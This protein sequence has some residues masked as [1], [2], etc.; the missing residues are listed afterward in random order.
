MKDD[1]FK[2]VEKEL[3]KWDDSDEAREQDKKFEE[4]INDAE[5]HHADTGRT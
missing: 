4:E 2:K 3:K 5:R 1:T